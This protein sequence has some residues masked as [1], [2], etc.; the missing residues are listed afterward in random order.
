MAAKADIFFRSS[1]PWHAGHS[2]AGEDPRTSVSNSLP[3]EL[4]EYSKMGMILVL[5]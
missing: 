3:Q 2:G 4:H 5:R 1:V